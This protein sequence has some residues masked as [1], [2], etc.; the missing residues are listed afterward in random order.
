[1][2]DELREKLR[3]IE[4]PIIGEDVVSAGLVEEIE[5]EDGV[6]EISLALGAPHSPAETEIAEQVR[7]VVRE[8]GYEPSLSV[9]ID[10][11]TPAAMVEDA[12]NVIAVSS[13]KG[14]VGKSTVAVN[15]AT[16]MTQRG[17]AVG[18]FDADVYG[19]NIPRMLGVYDHPGMAEDDETLIPV[20]R[21]GMKLK[22]RVPGR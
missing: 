19:P 16:A 21:F 4:D 12:P 11:K 14:G 13:G 6:A 9:D 7:E 8:A 22:H 1:M 3:G 17:A 15:L 5:L 20:E 18:L 2:T 10:D